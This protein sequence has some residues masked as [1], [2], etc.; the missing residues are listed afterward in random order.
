MV[1]LAVRLWALGYLLRVAF[2]VV[3]VAVGV[4]FGVSRP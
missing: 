2:T 3:A 1:R 4:Y